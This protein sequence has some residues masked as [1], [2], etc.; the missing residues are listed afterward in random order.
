MEKDTGSTKIPIGWIQNAVWKYLSFIE[1]FLVS[2][3]IYPKET[4]PYKN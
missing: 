1:D 3:S 4:A 2:L